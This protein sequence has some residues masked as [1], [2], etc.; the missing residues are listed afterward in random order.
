MSRFSGNEMLISMGGGG[1]W[2]RV[3]ELHKYINIYLHIHV[4]MVQEI[5]TYIN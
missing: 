4:H 5:H 2:G 1:G 3:D